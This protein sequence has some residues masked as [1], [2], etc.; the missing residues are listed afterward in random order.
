MIIYCAA[1]PPSGM[2]H[3]AGLRDCLNFGSDGEREG[4]STQRRT[5]FEARSSAT[6]RKS[7]RRWIEKNRA[8][9][10][11]QNLNSLL[12]PIRT[13]DLGFAQLRRPWA[14]LHCIA[15]SSDTAVY[16]LCSSV[17]ALV[18]RALPPTCSLALGPQSR[19]AD[20]LFLHDGSTFSDLSRFLWFAQILNPPCGSL[21]DDPEGTL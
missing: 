7:G 20:R 10:R 4:F 9:P 8:Q 21:L 2:A 3:R 11:I 14:A 15:V 17:A 1:R 13:P 12:E 5:T 6:R 16:S 19:N 18:S